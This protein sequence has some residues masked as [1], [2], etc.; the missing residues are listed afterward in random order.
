MEAIRADMLERDREVFEKKYPDASM[1]VL[2]AA[3]RLECYI[4]SREWKRND[5]QQARLIELLHSPAI[6]EESWFKEKL[7]IEGKGISGI[8]DDDKNPRTGVA[9][10]GW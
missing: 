3:L 8:F 9:G 4:L 6:H 7:R 1:F 10:R 5:W 2:S